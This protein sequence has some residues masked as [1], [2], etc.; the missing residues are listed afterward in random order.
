MSPSTS[1]FWT[2]LAVDPQLQA[3]LAE[4]LQLVGV[5]QHQ[6]R[7]GGGEVG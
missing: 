7:T 5:Q 6:C 1:A 4:S 2:P 3:E